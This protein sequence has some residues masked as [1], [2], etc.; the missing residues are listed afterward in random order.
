MLARRPVFEGTSTRRFR[1]RPLPSIPL[2]SSTVPADMSPTCTLP[3]EVLLEFVNDTNHSATMQVLRYED[4]MRSGAT[5]LIHS[6][7]SISLVLTAGLPYKYALRQHGKEANLRWATFESKFVSRY[8]ERR[9]SGGSVKVWHDSQC[10]ISDVF[11]ASVPVTTPSDGTYSVMDG[12]KVA[13]VSYSSTP[14]F[15]RL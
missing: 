12:V 10:N 6:G 3:Y 2:H 15:R 9:A 13:F 8:T 1:R 14:T 5:I 4:G 11:G 7:D